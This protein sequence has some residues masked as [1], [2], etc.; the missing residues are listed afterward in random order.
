M[1]LNGGTTN[2]N[3]LAGSINDDPPGG[4]SVGTLNQILDSLTI[5]GVPRAYFCEPDLNDALTAVCFLVDERVYNYEDYPDLDDDELI[6]KAMEVDW[7]LK[8]GGYKNVFLRQ[9]LK[10]KKLA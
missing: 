10:Y 8:L 5:N 2:G 4:S 7:I 1:I 9:L 6:S 3:I